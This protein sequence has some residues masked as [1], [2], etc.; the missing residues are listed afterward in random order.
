MAIFAYFSSPPW[1]C[2]AFQALLQILVTHCHTNGNTSLSYTTA[3]R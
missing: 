3:D 2:C 1:K